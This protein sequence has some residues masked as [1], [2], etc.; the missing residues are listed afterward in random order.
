MEL[1]GSNPRV[2]R[3]PQTSPHK[4]R[5]LSGWQWRLLVAA[6]LLG[7]VALMWCGISMVPVQPRADRYQ[8][9]FLEN[10]QVYFGKLSRIS[11][12][13]VQLDEAYYSKQ[14]TLPEDMSDE[15]AESLAANVALAKVG[16]ETYGPEDTLQVRADQILFWQDL[17]ED[18]KVARAIAQQP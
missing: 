14:Q 3:M 2:K 10:G 17:S 5:L 15:T 4:K 11:A 16:S 7:V 9:V 8:A 12:A 13:Y 6:G 18:S 1:I